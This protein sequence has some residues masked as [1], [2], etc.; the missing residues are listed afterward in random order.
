MMHY[1]NGD[2]Y[3]GEWMKDEN[4]GEGSIRYGETTLLHFITILL[5]KSQIDYNLLCQ[6]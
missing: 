3:E 5:S 6:D 4:H 1:E 2:I